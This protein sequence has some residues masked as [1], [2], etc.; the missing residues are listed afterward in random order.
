MFLQQRYGIRD[1][2]NTHIHMYSSTLWDSVS[3]TRF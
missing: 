1:L 2:K 3:A